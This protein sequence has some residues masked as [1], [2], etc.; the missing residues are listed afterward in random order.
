MKHKIINF[1]DYDIKPIEKYAAKHI[2][3]VDDRFFSHRNYYRRYLLSLS[4]EELIQEWLFINKI[5]QFLFDEIRNNEHYIEKP[6]LDYAKMIDEFKDNKDVSFFRKH[7]VILTKYYRT[8][9]KRYKE[10]YRLIHLFENDQKM[11]DIYIPKEFCYFL[12]SRCHTYSNETLYRETFFYSYYIYKCDLLLK[13]RINSI[14][15]V[16]FN[17]TPLY[18]HANKPVP[19]TNKVCADFTTVKHYISMFY[20]YV[21]AC[22]T[23]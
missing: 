10:I 17:Y 23:I 12:N 16:L 7:F 4:R 5:Y 21:N 2:E 14:K 20:R 6:L 8:H 3:D 11:M 15:D 1:K 22:N 19:G 13:N 9:Y 18:L